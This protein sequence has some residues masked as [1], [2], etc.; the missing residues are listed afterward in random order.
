MGFDDRK[1]EPLIVVGCLSVFCG[2]A[3]AVVGRL[4]GVWWGLLSVAPP[5]V[6]WAALVWGWRR[7]G[8]NGGSRRIPCSAKKGTGGVECPGE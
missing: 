6:V 1:T 7:E 5:V 3:V 8:R 2:L 4:F